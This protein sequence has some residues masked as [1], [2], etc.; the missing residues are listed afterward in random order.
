MRTICKHSFMRAVL[1]VSAFLIAGS[2]S[3]SSSVARPDFGVRGGAYTEAEEP[4]LGAEA[5]FNVGGSQHWFGNPNVEHA[6]IEGGDLTTL[7][8][9]LHYD[10]PSGQPYTIWAGA[11]PTVILR[12]RD[13][14]GDDDDTD[15]GM[16]LVFGL[17]ATRGEVRPYGQ[18]KVIVADDS[19]AVLGA[20]I[21][22]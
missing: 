15:P 16:N 22:F 8:F 3:I 1:S 6:F 13:T 5:L 18:V 19:Q 4:F 14:G 11:G 7:S 12:D 20:G 2:L 17:G 21:R 10:F 9:D